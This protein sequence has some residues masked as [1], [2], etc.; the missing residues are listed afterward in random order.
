MSTKH[1]NIKQLDN[2]KF[3]RTARNQNK[4]DE[5]ISLSFILPYFNKTVLAI[6]NTMSYILVVL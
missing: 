1:E 5:N 3:F 2:L 6:A 4:N